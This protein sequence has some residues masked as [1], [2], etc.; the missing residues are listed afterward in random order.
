MAPINMKLM[1]L[2]RARIALEPHLTQKMV[3]MELGE[4]P[5]RF[6]KMLLGEVP[7]SLDMR[8]KAIQLLNLENALKKMAE[9][10]AK[11]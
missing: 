9:R 1:N 8:F 11:R 7:M 3:A 2:I 5:K 6:N 10:K 4:E